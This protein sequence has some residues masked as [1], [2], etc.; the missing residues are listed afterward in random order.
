MTDFEA[1][2]QKNLGYDITYGAHRSVHA[3]QWTG[4]EGDLVAQ[5]R[6]NWPSVSAQRYFDGDAYNQYA[7]TFVQTALQGEART[8]GDYQRLSGGDDYTPQIGRTKIMQASEYPEMEKLDNGDNQNE[9]LIV[10][11]VVIG[12]LGLLF[13]VSR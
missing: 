1:A 7:K 12:V 13:F 9:M 10:G 3:P 2:R 5:T 8:M 6:M 4:Y 11:F